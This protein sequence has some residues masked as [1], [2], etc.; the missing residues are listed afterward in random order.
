[1]I[2][3]NIKNLI[4]EM[5]EE[6]IRNLIKE[7]RLEV[8]IEKKMLEEGDH[9]KVGNFEE[10]IRGLEINLDEKKETLKVIHAHHKEI[11]R[12]EKNLLVEE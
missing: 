8:M 11:Q 7:M 1:M 9:K 10:L 3:K 4:K 12:E 6:M 5:I 2:K